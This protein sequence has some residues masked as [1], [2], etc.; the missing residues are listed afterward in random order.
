MFSREEKLKFMKSLMWDYNIP[1]EDCLDVLEGKKEM[2]GHYNED[3]LFRKLLLS[4]PWFTILELIPFE[5][6]VFLMKQKT[7]QS[8]W[9]KSMSAKYEFVRTRLLKIV[10]T[11]G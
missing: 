9:P 3:T 6:I 7:V 11:P 8:L 5:R 4:F 2:A 1:P 10:S